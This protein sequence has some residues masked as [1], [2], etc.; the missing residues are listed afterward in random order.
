MI[1]SPF[2]TG[3]A[4]RNARWPF[5]GKQCALEFSPPG[6]EPR[7]TDHAP[8]GNEASDL[9][10]SEL[11]CLEEVL[12]S[13]RRESLRYSTQVALGSPRHWRRRL[14]RWLV[15]V[16]NLNS[17]VDADGGHGPAWMIAPSQR[18]VH[19]ADTV[20][21]LRCSHSLR[22]SVDTRNA[23]RNPFGTR[24]ATRWTYLMRGS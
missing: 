18:G 24:V 14:T 9:H 20:S 1:S 19:K 5:E 4:L 6:D 12:P 11:T 15:V 10:R 3:P 22:I 17:R 8:Y 13:S 16:E 21:V 2:V 23:P 7:A